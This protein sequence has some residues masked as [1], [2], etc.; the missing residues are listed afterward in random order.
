MEKRTSAA[1]AI[2]TWTLL[3]GATLIAYLPALQGRLLWDDDHHV[4][5]PELQ[6]LHGLWRIWFDIGATQ[7]YYPLLHSAFWVE[8]RFWGDAVLGY[9]LG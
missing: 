1:A 8:H 2:G 9:P 6:S 7:Q 5:S 4:T 3:F